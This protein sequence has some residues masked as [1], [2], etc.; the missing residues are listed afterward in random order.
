MEANPTVGHTFRQE[1]YPGHAEDQFK[2]VNLASPIHVPYGS[3][4]D[5]LLTQEWTTLEPGVLDHKYYV[6]GVGE[7][8]EV[9]VKGPDERLFLVSYTGG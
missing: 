9:S 5:A 1:Y 8:A 7:V 3:F 6:K 4:A 2:V